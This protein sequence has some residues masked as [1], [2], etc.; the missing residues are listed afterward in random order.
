MKNPELTQ[1]ESKN[2]EQQ[3][4]PLSETE[5][6]VFTNL[7]PRLEELTVKMEKF[8][9]QYGKDEI[10]ADLEKIRIKKEHIEESGQKTES[11]KKKRSQILEGVLTE[12]IEL[13]NWFGNDVSTVVASEFDDLFNGIDLILE[14]GDTDNVGID[15]TSTTERIEKK[16]SIIKEHILRGYLSQA[17]YF[18]SEKHDPKR[19][20]K[21][22]P[23]LIVGVGSELVQE[24]SELWLTTNSLRIAGKSPLELSEEQRTLVR[25]AREGLANNRIA[26]LLL[27][28]IK[29]QLETFEKFAQSKGQAKAAKKFKRLL[30]VI[31][32]K[33][34]QK[35]LAPEEE[36]KNNQDI[37]FKALKLNLQKVFS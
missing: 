33:L 15:V 14:L 34:K 12:Q 4:T 37:I 26:V 16:L 32:E 10:A 11:T 29:T 5:T 19:K 23:Q 21:R 8:E 1:T 7:L 13:S 35:K 27:Q 18:Q 2:K 31:E 6:V 30:F 24:I 20:I 25:Q 28:Q 22:L 36:E 9:D 17:K 3:E